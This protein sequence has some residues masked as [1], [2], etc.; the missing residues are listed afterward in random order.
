MTQ[1]EICKGCQKEKVI[2]KRHSCK[3]CYDK[4]MDTIHQFTLGI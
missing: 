1:L 4:M 2:Y 3:E